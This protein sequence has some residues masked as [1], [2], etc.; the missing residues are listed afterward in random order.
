M[1]YQLDSKMTNED[2]VEKLRDG[3]FAGQAHESP[4][5]KIKNLDRLLGGSFTGF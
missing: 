2:V 5:V 3:L 4:Q 1:C